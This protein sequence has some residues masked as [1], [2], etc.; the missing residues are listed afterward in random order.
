MVS[1][2]QPAGEDLPLDFSAHIRVNRRVWEEW[3]KMFDHGPIG[4]RWGR[5]AAL[6][7]FMVD[8]ITKQSGE[9]VA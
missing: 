6:H 1:T 8:Q 9:G 3:G 4:K 2:G 7:R 5:S